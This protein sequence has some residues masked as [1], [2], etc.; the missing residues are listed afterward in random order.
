MSIYVGGDITVLIFL[1]GIFREGILRGTSV[2]YNHGL[3]FCMFE[4]MLRFTLTIGNTNVNRFLEHHDYEQ[5]ITGIDT[6]VVFKYTI[7]TF[8]FA[9]LML[10]ICTIFLNSYN[11][12]T[13]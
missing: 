3:C 8:F 10:V 12:E 13:L 6:L 2:Y 1:A 11:I 9:S 5:P 7:K 4:K